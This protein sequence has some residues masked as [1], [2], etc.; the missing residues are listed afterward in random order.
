MRHGRN[1]LASIHPADKIRAL[2][3]SSADVES[4]RYQSR[5]LVIAQS[6]GGGERVG[7]GVLVG[8]L[9]ISYCSVAPLRC[10]VS[11]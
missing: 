11:S 8:L 6:N 3:V 7:K 5:V 9:N 10:I 2:H 1:I 4:P